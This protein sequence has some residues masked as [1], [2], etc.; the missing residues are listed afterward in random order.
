[1]ISE[2][3]ALSKKST[4][5]EDEKEDKGEGYP[6]ENKGKMLVDATVA[7]QAIRYPTDPSL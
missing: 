2:K 5:N 4:A 6:V 7:E 3:L 1:M